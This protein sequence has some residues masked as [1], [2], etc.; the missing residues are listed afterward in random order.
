M[1]VFILNNV[2]FSG[3]G[4]LFTLLK[5]LQIECDRQSRKIIQGFKTKRN[6][7]HVVSYRINQLESH[8][9]KYMYLTRYDNLIKI[10]CLFF[11]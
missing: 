6:L 3:A 7:D 11:L 1:I 2:T 8:L 5:I 10:S 4:R 9:S